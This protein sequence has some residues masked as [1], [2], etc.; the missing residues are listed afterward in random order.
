MEYLHKFLN[1]T[2]FHLSGCIHI[3]QLELFHSE[4]K[5]MKTKSKR[6]E[7]QNFQINTSPFSY[8]LELTSLKIIQK[9][10]SYST[11]SLLTDLFN[12]NQAI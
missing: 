9:I 10:L 7:I 6:K 12:T 8:T 11:E 3:I 5:P 4:I 1:T 2:K